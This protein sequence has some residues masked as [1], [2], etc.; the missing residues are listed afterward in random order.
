[1]QVVLTRQ[2]GQSD[3]YDLAV[4]STELATTSAELVATPPV[5]CEDL[6]GQVAPLLMWNAGKMGFTMR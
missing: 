3:G 1:V 5:E 4:V 6:P 2:P